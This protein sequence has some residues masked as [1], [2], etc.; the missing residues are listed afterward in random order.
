MQ[1]VED[2]S[3]LELEGILQDS[4]AARW[5]C[6]FSLREITPNY[7]ELKS[8]RRKLGIDLIVELLSSLQSQLRE[9]GYNQNLLG[10]INPNSLVNLNRC[11]RKRD[12][13]IMDKL[14]L[15]NKIN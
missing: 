15:Q 14:T 1:V 11:W 3:Y 7:K 9:K 12:K 13:V 6:G 8:I 4:T 10:N 5:F 2:L